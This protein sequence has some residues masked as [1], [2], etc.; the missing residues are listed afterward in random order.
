MKRSGA[1]KERT[2]RRLREIPP[3]SW[4][5][6]ETKMDILATCPAKLHAPNWSETRGR[7][8]RG[9]KLPLRRIDSRRY[10]LHALAWGRKTIKA[11]RW[12]DLSN[13]R[14]TLPAGYGILLE[15]FPG[16]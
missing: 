15:I 3:E 16:D 1:G 13:L 9:A 8:H 6:R 11:R 5:T 12:G 10:L 2:K 7:P 14:A 4:R